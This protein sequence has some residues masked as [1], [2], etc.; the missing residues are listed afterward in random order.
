MHSLTSVA[1]AVVG[2]LHGD[3]G[4]TSTAMSPGKR[5]RVSGYLEHLEKLKN[6]HESGVLCADEFDEQK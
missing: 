1:T 3:S 4:A 5:A 6:L 2:L